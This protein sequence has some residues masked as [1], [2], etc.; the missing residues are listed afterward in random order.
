MHS[1]GHI[2]REKIIPKQRNI[3]G[4]LPRKTIDLSAEDVYLLSVA[5]EREGII[6]SAFAAI[7][8]ALEQAGRRMSMIG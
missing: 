2:L 4:R 3:G 1:A 7:A 8:A 5:L 6:D